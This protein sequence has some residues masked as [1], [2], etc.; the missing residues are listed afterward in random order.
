MPLQKAP[1]DH[2][3][4]YLPLISIF[5]LGTPQWYNLVKQIRKDLKDQQREL[6]RRRRREWWS[7]VLKRKR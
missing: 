4:I 6:Q 1:M 7:R 2:L 3:M 5:V